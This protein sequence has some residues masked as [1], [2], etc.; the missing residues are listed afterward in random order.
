MKPDAGIVGNGDSRVDVDKALGREDVEQGGV[1]GAPDAKTLVPLLD[2]D[3]HLGI[4][5]VCRPGAETARVDEA[6]NFVAPFRNQPRINLQRVF[7]PGGHLVTIRCLGFEGDR[8]LV[9]GRHVDGGDL[10]GILRGG[11]PDLEPEEGDTL[12]VGLVISPQSLPNWEFAVDYFDLE[13]DGGIGGIFA[14]EICFDV[15]NNN[16][17]IYK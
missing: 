17:S 3:R 8:A 2:K 13:M 15:R 11:N 10:R 12:T 7:D 4:P 6:H 9:D 5:V 16:N 1:D 14:D